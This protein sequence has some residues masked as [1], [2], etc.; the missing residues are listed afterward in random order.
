M[1]PV[2]V[3][4]SPDRSAATGA[5]AAAAERRLTEGADLVLLCRVDPVSGRPATCNTLTAEAAAVAADVG[6]AVVA[7]L[8]DAVVDTGP[9]AGPRGGAWSQRAVAARSGG[10]RVLASVPTAAAAAAEVAAVAAFANLVGCTYLVTDQPRAARRAV[11][12][13][14]ASRLGR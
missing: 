8:G 10:R 5:T 4:D 13:L 1:A 7:S 2:V 6:G 12:T 14:S 11:E 3:G 9:V